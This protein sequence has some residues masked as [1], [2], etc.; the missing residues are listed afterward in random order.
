MAIEKAEGILLGSSDGE[1]GFN[2]LSPK[3]YGGYIFDANL[4]INFSQPS[5]MQL[6]IVS[7]NGK[8]DEDALAK[9]IFPGQGTV[10]SPPGN[11]TDVLPIS[12]RG[13]AID[14]DQIYFGGKTFNMHP[15]KYSIS[16]GPNGRYLQMDYYDRSI[17]FLDKVLVMLDQKHLPPVYNPQYPPFV[18]SAVPPNQPNIIPVGYPYVSARDQDSGVP[19]K[20]SN[21]ASLSSKLPT[22]LYSPI[23]LYYGMYNCPALVGRL[24]PSCGILLQYAS[25]YGGYSDNNSNLLKDYAGTLRDVLNAWSQDLGFIFYWEVTTDTLGIMDLR[26][27]I[28]FNTIQNSVQKALSARNIIDRTWSYSIEDTFSK[29]IVANFARE[30]VAGGKDTK[31]S[32]AGLDLLE[33]NIHKCYVENPES[34]AC[35]EDEGEEESSIY[36]KTNYCAQS[37]DANGEGGGGSK[38]ASL[39]MSNIGAEKERMVDYIRLLKAAAIGP[40]FY[41]AYVLHKK[42]ASHSDLFPKYKEGSFKNDKE[43]ADAL[44]VSSVPEFGVA[45]SG[46]EGGGNSIVDELYYSSGSSDFNKILECKEEL[47][48]GQ[49]IIKSSYIVGQ[50]CISIE[51]LDQKLLQYA[52]LY[53]LAQARLV[54]VSSNTSESSEGGVGSFMLC[55]LKKYGLRSIITSAEDDHIFKLLNG[56]ALNQGRFSYSTTLHTQKSASRKSFPSGNVQWIDRAQDVNDTP[57][58]P[59]YNSINPT[60]ALA[61]SPMPNSCIKDKDRASKE[62]NCDGEDFDDPPNTARPT[63]EQFIQSIVN[64]TV[65]DQEDGSPANLSVTIAGGVVTNISITKAGEGYLNSGNGEITGVVSGVGS[66]ASFTAKITDGQVSAII[67]SS[68]GSGYD[69]DTTAE[70]PGST[71]FDAK[72]NIFGEDIESFGESEQDSILSVNLQN[73]NAECQ[74]ACDKNEEIDNRKGV[75]LIDDGN[76]VKIPNLIQKRIERFVNGFSIIPSNQNLSVVSF[77]NEAGYEVLYMAA[78]SSI[79]EIQALPEY[80]DWFSGRKSPPKDELDFI[81]DQVDIPGLDNYS[82]EGDNKTKSITVTVS[83]VGDKFEKSAFVRPLYEANVKELTVDFMTPSLEDLGAED[84]DCEES[85]DPAKKAEKIKNDDKVVERNIL[86]YAQSFAYQQDRVEYNARIV[87]ADAYLQ[88]KSKKPIDL[89]IENGLE[90]MT[91]SVSEQGTRLTFSI[92]TRRKRRVINKPSTDMWMRVKPEFYNKIFDI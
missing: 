24:H 35:G 26:A 38:W 3:A 37:D 72:K 18:G 47:P 64:D 63:I 48:N 44:N 1:G 20:P 86:N 92:G 9:R 74:K 21:D 43:A 70:V 36:N 8:Y 76:K 15:L 49:K 66:G 4:S 61:S 60:A 11:D 65:V 73:R 7:E 25:I 32:F 34:V 2:A 69:E 27:P 14:Y 71:G 41:R 29:G 55:R 67:I 5:T 78:P 53:N 10:S 59:L 19:G 51:R 22:Y 89:L 13:G 68:G 57:L 42:L 81:V 91:A 54:Q 28:Q 85:S 30:G 82:K 84:A 17:S 46:G 6:S 80:K 50:D 45:G 23:H 16:E 83:E 88:D 77:L 62:K 12:T 52:Q 87:V 90:S 79:S 39:E 33:L 40:E 56:I 75:L 58:G 31:M